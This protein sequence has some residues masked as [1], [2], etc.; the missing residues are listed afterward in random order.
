MGQ[1]ASST[2]RMARPSSTASTISMETSTTASRMISAKTGLRPPRMEQISLRRVEWVKLITLLEKMV[3]CSS[4]PCGMT[5][6]PT[7]SGW[8][9]H[10]QWTVLIQVQCEARV[11]QHRVRLTTWKRSRAAPRSCFRTSGGV[12]WAARPVVHHPVL[13]HLRVPLLRVVAVLGMVNIVV[14]RLPTA[15]LRRLSV[16]IVMA[17]GAPTASHRLCQHLHQHQRLLHHQHRRHLQ[18]QVDALAGLLMHASTSV[19][20]MSLHSVLNLARSGAMMLWSEI[21]VF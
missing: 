13:H 1:S 18:A 8:T 21:F 15:K 11:P 16:R 20:V 7:C 9:L 5:T 14:T 4:C 10:T 2:R 12:H 17:S 6:T 3:L 19:Q